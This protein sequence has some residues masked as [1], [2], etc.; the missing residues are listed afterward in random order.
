MEIIEKFSFEKLHVYQISLDWVELADNILEKNKGQISRAFADQLSR[1][2]TSIP[3]NIAEG[4]GRW[5]KAEKRQFFWISRGS[6]FECV[7][8]LEILHRKNLIQVE[9][10]AQ[11]RGQLSTIAKMLTNL[12]KAQN[13]ERPNT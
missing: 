1:A 2:S 13:S 8:I 7:A 9:E 4:N 12:I 6:V 3:L 11:Y 10:M 5:H